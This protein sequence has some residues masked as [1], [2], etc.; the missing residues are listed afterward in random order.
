M[1]LAAQMYQHWIRPQ[2]CSISSLGLP[3][4][5]KHLRKKCTNVFVTGVLEQV[6]SVPSRAPWRTCMLAINH[7]FGS[8]SL[9][10][11]NPLNYPPN[12]ALDW[13]NNNTKPE[14]NYIYHRVIWIS[15]S[16]WN[17]CLSCRIFIW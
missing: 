7:S 9:V 13:L 8:L 17:F 2:G 6:F 3:F 5:H 10:G 15:A 12:E 14:I 1:C 11:S 4:P 16:V